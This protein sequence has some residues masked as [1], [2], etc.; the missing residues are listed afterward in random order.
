MVRPLLQ[1]EA[2]CLLSPVLPSG[3]GGGCWA[4]SLCWLC[5]AGLVCACAGA[6]NVGDGQVSPQ[7]GSGVLCSVTWTL[8]EPCI[9]HFF[10]KQFDYEAVANK[11]FKLASRQSTPS[12]NRKRLYKVIQK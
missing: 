5:R 2:G 3:R 8:T 12:Q 4:S 1:K 11:L 7:P 10:L 6:G 9:S